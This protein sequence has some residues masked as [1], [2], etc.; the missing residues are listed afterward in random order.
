MKRSRGRWGF[1]LVLVLVLVLGGLSC[2]GD[3]RALV[4]EGLRASERCALAVFDGGVL[5]ASVLDGGTR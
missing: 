5:D 1:V 4:L 3:E 2:H